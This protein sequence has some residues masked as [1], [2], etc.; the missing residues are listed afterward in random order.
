M[1]PAMSQV[2]TNSSSSRRIPVSPSLCPTPDQRSVAPVALACGRAGPELLRAMPSLA[3]A[4]T[5]LHAQHLQEQRQVLE[6]AAG[7]PFRNESGDAD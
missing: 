5:L 6:A 4:A 3:A 2:A 1:W 7:L